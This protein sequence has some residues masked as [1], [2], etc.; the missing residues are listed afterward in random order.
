MDKNGN[1]FSVEQKNAN[2]TDSPKKFLFVSFESLSGD[3]AWQIKKEG[4]QVKVFIGAEGDQD[5]YDGFLDKTSNWEKDV[6]WADIIIFD[7]IGFGEH[8]D[9]LRKNGKLVVGGSKY[10]DKIEEDREFAQNE[11]KR[12][13][14]L[15]LPHEDFSNFDDAI[16]FIKKNPGRYVFKPSGNTPSDQKGILFLGQDDDGKDLIE[17]LEQNKKLWAKKIRKFQL[18][19]MAVGVEVAV[20]AFFNG[21]DFIYPINVNFEHKKLYPGDIGPYTGEMGTLMFWGP[22]NE[23]FNST[24]I[25]IKDDL[26]KSGY[27]GYIDINCIAN[28]KGIYP[29]EFTSRFGYPTISIQ[30]EGVNSGWGDFFYSI[31]K[32]EKFELK[33]KKGFQIGVI[34]AIPPFPFDDKKEAFIYKDLS[35]LFRKPSLDGVH[36]GDVKLVNDVWSIAGESGYAL[37]I[38]GS[39]STVEEASKQVYS[40]VKNIML[41]NMYYRTDIGFRWNSDSDRLHT[42]GYLYH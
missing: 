23:I 20:G 14:M 11:M 18:Q 10:T 12:V 42:W 21:E 25:K 9:K 3:L 16:D 4:H 24:L 2:L 30:I 8:A 13:G 7:D 15:V 36:L 26:A 19:K 41:Q 38:T 39:G 1:N 35:I 22:T 17:I 29:L 31:A 33:T 40:R 28:A 5:V 32:K 37:V 27:V 34:I 6:D